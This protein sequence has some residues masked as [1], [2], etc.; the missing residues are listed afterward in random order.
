MSLLKRLLHTGSAGASSTDADWWYLVFDTGSGCF[1][2]VHEWGDREEHCRGR[3]T[4]GTVLLE[5]AAYLSRSDDP[6][7]RELVRLI[8]AMFE[9]GEGNGARRGAP[10][11]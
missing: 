7:R 9:G 3:I 4:G 8:C 5:V 10:S 11:A 6:G 1:G 2:V